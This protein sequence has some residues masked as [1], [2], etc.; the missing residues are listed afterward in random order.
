L[1]DT[2][3]KMRTGH[4][5][6]WI[7]PLSMIGLAACQ[8]APPEPA[9]EPPTLRAE[10]IRT[11]TAE[12]IHALVEEQGGKVVAVNFWASWCPPC[13]EEFPDIIDVYEDLHSEGLEVIAVSMNFEDEMEDI[14]A[15]LGRYRPP[16]PVY[17][18][19][20]MD[21]AFLEG[22]VAGWYGEIP[23]TLVFDAGGNLV[24]FHKKLVTYDEL[25]GEVIP[26][27]PASGD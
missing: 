3:R 20:S 9:P 17:R 7:L 5:R 24:H 6:G 27:L 1:D 18:A 15:F 25:A 13:L 12:E 10:D 19:A 26:L 23:V 21:E 2:E 8:A 11:V 14:D 16:F 22:V 4:I